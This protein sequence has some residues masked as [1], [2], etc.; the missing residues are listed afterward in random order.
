MPIF[1]LNNGVIPIIAYNYGAQKRSR[2]MQAV[3][4]QMLIAVGMMA[5][6][7]LLF[8]L[9][10]GSLL[11]MFITNA[12]VQEMEIMMR[13]GKPALRIICT[14]FI[15]AAIS[16]SLTSFFQALGKGVYAM[17]MS[18]V[19]QLVVLLP[20]AYVLALIGQKVGNDNLVWISYPIAE[21]VAIALALY[22]FGR[23]KRKVL[24]KVGD[25]GLPQTA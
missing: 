19:R 20:A 11:K 16:I 9:I 14:P 25:D 13:I 24:S 23:L 2:M 10:P 8:L 4:V 21:I 1:G 5:V 7:T 15:L 22:Y 6:G 18:M 12:S 17:I 3:K